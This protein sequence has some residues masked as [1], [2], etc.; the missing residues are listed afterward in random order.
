MSGFCGP[1]EGDVIHQNNR[2]RRAWQLIDERNKARLVAVVFRDIVMD[3]SLPTNRH[4]EG[5]LSPS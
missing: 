1:V 4:D 3:D 2:S 5:N